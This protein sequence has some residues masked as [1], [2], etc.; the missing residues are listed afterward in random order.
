MAAWRETVET[1]LLA[2]CVFSPSADAETAPSL[3]PRR[4]PPLR[5]IEGEPSSPAESGVLAKVM[6]SLDSLSYAL[7]GQCLKYAFLQRLVLV[8]RL[9]VPNAWRS[10]IFL[11]CL[12]EPTQFCQG[13]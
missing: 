11:A 13:L 2:F 7:S 9:A 6:S 8:R 3:Q 1:E 5:R 10:S 4:R 12:D